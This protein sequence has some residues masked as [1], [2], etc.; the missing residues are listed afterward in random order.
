VMN[1]DG[2]GLATLTSDGRAREGL[3]WSRDGST[4]VY[5]YDTENGETIAVSN[6]DGSGARDLARGS[7]P[8][9][10]PDGREIVFAGAN[11][12]VSI[13]RADGT[14]LRRLAPGAD[15]RWSP[16][17]KHIAFVRLYRGRPGLYVIRTDGTSVRRIAG[18]QDEYP[19]DPTWS[20]DS[21]RI[22][23]SGDDGISIVNADG[24]GRRALA[25]GLGSRL[26]WSPDGRRLV[27]AST[28]DDIVPDDDVE[29]ELYVMDVHTGRDVR[30]LAFT[31]DEWL[32]L[33]QV[34]SAAGKVVASF[35]ATGKP[36]EVAL[37][38]SV[39]ALL[40][41]LSDGSTRISV[42]DARTGSPRRVVRVAR[43]THRG[44]ASDGRRILFSGRRM[45]RSLDVRT[46]KM[47]VLTRT[48]GAPIGLSVSGGRVAWAEK[49]A[50]KRA[51]IRAVRLP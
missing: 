30:G 23:F 18:R 24:S 4:F 40:S 32:S 33:G 10:S 11:G 31:R 3:D 25:R 45:I 16:D 36:V 49:L 34:R 8:D 5:S 51:R 15:P 29:S 14:G 39:V 26:D 27:F 6:A 12:T 37:S 28:R 41:E 19:S 22:A 2:S 7:D 46:G 38:E 20:P 1:A 35:S 43:E 17:G 13:V 44:L 9:W 48:R 47:R 42:F 50:P 21:R